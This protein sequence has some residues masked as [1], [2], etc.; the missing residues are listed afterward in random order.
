MRPKQTAIS[1]SR[2]AL[3][4]RAFV[5]GGLVSAFLIRLYQL[6][7]SSLWYDETVSAY[8]ARQSITDMIAHTALD[9]HPPAYYLM[10]HGWSAVNAPLVGPA[11]EFLFAFPSLWFGVITIALLVP[12]GRTLLGHAPTALAVWLAAL[13]PFLVWYGQEVRMYTVAGALGL[14]CL[15]AALRYTRLRCCDES[16]SWSLP[17]SVAWLV[18]Y[19]LAAAAGLYTLYYTAFGLVAINVAVL[20]TMLVLYRSGVRVVYAL[21]GWIVAQMAVLILF[22]PWLP[23]F[24]R[25]ILD[26]PVPPWRAPWASISDMAK[27]A[28][29]VMSAYVVGQSVPVVQVWFWAGLAAV[30]LLVYYGYTKSNRDLL[31]PDGGLGNRPYAGG[32]LFRYWLP[33]Y[34]LVPPLTVVAVTALSIPIFHVR[35]LST[36]APAFA[37]IAAAGLTYLFTHHRLLFGLLAALFAAGVV[38]SLARSWYHPAYQTDDHRSAVSTLAHAWRP[39]DAILANAG[40]VYTALDTYWPTTLVGPYDVLP[41]GPVEWIRL[42][43]VPTLSV[44][45]NDGRPTGL[46]TGSVEGDPSLGWGSEDADFYATSRDDTLASLQAMGERFPRIWHYRLYDTVNDPDAVI[47]DWLAENLALGT[48]QT[49]AGDGFL[50]L[51]QYSSNS[52]LAR[53]PANSHESIPFGSALALEDYRLPDLIPAGSYLYIPVA[54]RA[55]QDSP[56][57]DTPLAASLRLVDR[58]SMLWAQQDIP[59]IPPEGTWSPGKLFSHVLAV[60]IPAAT[61]PG[62]YDVQL[63]IYNADD[64]QPLAVVTADG[65][66]DAL[67]LGSIQIGLPQSQPIVTDRLTRFDYIDLVRADFTAGPVVPGEQ[68]HADFVWRPAPS[69]Y[70]D[71]YGSR[72]ILAREDGTVAAAWERPLGGDSYPSSMWPTLFPVRDQFAVD[73]PENLDDGVYR[74]LIEVHRSS[75]GLQIPAQVRRWWPTSSAAYE[76]GSVTVGE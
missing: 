23:R 49:F 55:A 32:S 45:D 17:G 27:D 52:D 76:L 53:T 68:L 61:P 20:V 29:S 3:T 36:Y 25:Q 50:L 34:A 30:F 5:L 6:G 56:P 75:D 13:H 44:Q 47:R 12:I 64:L 69:D 35:Y 65:S 46:T 9:I 43:D 73:L 72:V 66:V 62:N 15:L 60:P 63:I 10:L 1:G 19:A 74:V 54:W 31:H 16:E 24:T 48:S 38:Y 59:V 11:M 28:A 37:L 18:L 57:L 39:E 58:D 22:A 2:K 71:A 42:T 40:W 8:L 4:Y 33:I 26:P 67:V 7:A 41:G 14:L 21:S 70:R 51:E